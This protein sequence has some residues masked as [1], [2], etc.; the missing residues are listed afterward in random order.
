VSSDRS[1]G[2]GLTPIVGW[3]RKEANIMSFWGKVNNLSLQDFRPGIKSKAEIGDRLIMALM[4]IGPDKEDTGH[5]HPFEQCGIVTEGE[6][7]MFVGD[8]HQIL[9]PMD[10]YFIPAGT[11]HGWKT[12]AA[13][14]KILDVSVKQA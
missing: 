9:K 7:E 10:V 1:Q 6:I 12:F 8:E 14:V 2:F 4:E 5:Q 3:N 11:L 13:S